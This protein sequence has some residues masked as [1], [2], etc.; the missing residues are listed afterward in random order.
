LLTL[1]VL[2]RP[3]FSASLAIAGLMTFGMYA[4]LFIMP[5]YFQTARSATPFVAGLDL[6][7]MPVA[8]FLVSQFVGHLNNRF[9]PRAVMTAGMSC[10]GAGALAL[11]MVG[12]D[13]SLVFIEPALL[14]VGIGLGLN[15]APVNGV[16]VAALP[17][18]R[19]GTAS[20]LLNTTRMVGATL[21]VAILASVFAS[22]AGA[23][24]AMGGGFLAGMRAALTGGAAAEFLGA[25]IALVFIHGDA[26]KQTG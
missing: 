5:L 22:H 19:F 3:A 9:G 4:L 17:P 10:M 26:L 15:T 7:P 11:A 25:V 21:G 2:R 18:A 23:Q 14:V 24:A 12:G 1:E 8:V 13:T 6:L 16:A 20:G